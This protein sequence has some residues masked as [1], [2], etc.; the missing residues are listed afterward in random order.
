MKSLTMVASV[1]ALLLTAASAANASQSIVINPPASDGSISGVFMGNE[2]A[3]GAF[4]DTF[5]FL[6]PVT[7]VTGA[8]ISSIFNV[9]QNNDVNFSSVT[10]NG[11]SFQIDSVGNFESRHIMNLPTLGGPQS[12]VV[13]GTSGGNGA[14]AGTIAFSPIVGV[15]EPASWA[16]MIMGFG[17]LG[18]VLRTRKRVQSATA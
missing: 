14:F 12:L 7:G 1:A 5:S 13:S 10:L 11:V 18:S 17:G 2:I 3:S 15:P 6:L 9:A 16:L 8:T 4:T